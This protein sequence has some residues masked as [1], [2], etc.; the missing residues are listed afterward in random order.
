MN[1]S[2]IFFCQTIVGSAHSVVMG[3]KIYLSPYPSAGLRIDLQTGESR[4]SSIWQSWLLHNRFDQATHPRRMPSRVQLWLER[5]ALIVAVC[6]LV[7][8]LFATALVS[9]SWWLWR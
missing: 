6:G 4:L 8:V 3:K 9:W 2:E 7:G 1:D 5:H